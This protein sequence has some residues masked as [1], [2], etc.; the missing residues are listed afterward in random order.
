MHEGVKVRA[1]GT[2]YAYYED[3]VRGPFETSVAA[4]KAWDMLCYEAE[5]DP[6][7]L[8]YPE[9]LELTLND[10]P[11][12]GEIRESYGGFG[13][14]FMGGAG[15][16]DGGATGESGGRSRGGSKKPTW[17]SPRKEKVAEVDIPTVVGYANEE[18][19]DG[20]KGEGRR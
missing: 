2:W 4:A 19:S 20:R 5:G 11:H 12:L 16:G 1:D 3:E 6:E 17:I 7:L 13:D 18:R 10:I 8:N 14:G 15:G 9:R